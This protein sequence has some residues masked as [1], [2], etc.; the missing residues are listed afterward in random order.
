MKRFLAGRRFLGTIAL[1]ALVGA[2]A[3]LVGPRVARAFTLTSLAISYDPV[4]VPIDHTLHVNIVNQYNGNK[5][6][7]RA[8]LTP[9]TPAAGSPLLGAPIILNPGEGS[10]EAF[11]FAGFSPPSGANRVP[12]VVEILVTPGGTPTTP[13]IDWSAK[14][15]TSVEIIDDRTGVQTAILG[16]R[17]IVVFPTLTGTSPTFCLFCN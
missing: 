14:L 10:D 3:S 1:L 15:A 7:V 12:V 9:T 4:S 5:V 17:H 16:S 13:L 2:A 11:P 6:I 8:L